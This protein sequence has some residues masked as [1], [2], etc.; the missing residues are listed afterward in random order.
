MTYN[1]LRNIPTTYNISPES[2]SG[3]S[4][5]ARNLLE[6][7]QNIQVSDSPRSDNSKFVSDLVQES[8][9][10]GRMSQNSTASSLAENLIVASIPYAIQSTKTGESS[11]AEILVAK[12]V[13][14]GQ[15]TESPASEFAE[16]L[17]T[18]SCIVGKIQNQ[19]DL[20]WLKKL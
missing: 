1:I 4:V 11:V 14:N 20:V 3:E 10:V 6:G 7:N 18:K 15:Y 2:L 19:L 8:M 13:M 9:V 16:N 17:I 12:S 5:I